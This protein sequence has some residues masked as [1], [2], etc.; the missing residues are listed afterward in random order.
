MYVH[1]NYFHW[2]YICTWNKKT[3]TWR[4]VY[5]WASPSSSDQQL[6]KF[7]DVSGN[8]LRYPNY[9][10]TGIT[11]YRTVPKYQNA[12]VVRL[13]TEN[14]I[15]VKIDPKSF[16]LHISA[17]KIVC[18][19]YLSAFYTQRST[20]S[21]LHVELWSDWV[22]ALADLRL[23][24]VHMP[25]CWFCHEAAHLWNSRRAGFINLISDDPPFAHMLVQFIWC[26]SWLQYSVCYC[27]RCHR[28]SSS[29]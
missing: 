27:S 20:V 17:P 28:Y 12:D 3:I 22:D 7:C 21:F 16:F 4:I 2:K 23:C 11:N 24:W 5:T 18:M 26:G 8:P 25:F 10:I 9:R 14:S 1:W 29:N 19:L 15:F 6:P 13:I